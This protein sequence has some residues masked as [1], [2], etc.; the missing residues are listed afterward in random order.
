MDSLIL[1]PLNLGFFTQDGSRKRARVETTRSLKKVKVSTFGAAVEH[2]INIDVEDLCARNILTPVEPL[3]RPRFTKQSMLTGYKMSEV[4]GTGK[5]CTVRKAVDLCTRQTVAIKIMN[6]YCESSMEDMFTHAE[7]EAQLLSELDHPNIVKFIRQIE[8]PTKVYTVLEYVQGTDL[9]TYVTRNP[10]E[11]K[12]LFKQLASTLDY[13]HTQGVA[14]RDVKP[15][16]L[17]VDTQGNL[18]IV[19]FGM[20]VRYH[21]QKINTSCGTPSYAS[22]EA[23]MG[24]NYNGPELDSWSVGVVLFQMTT[25]TLPF[26]NVSETLQGQWNNQAPQLCKETRELVQGLLCMEPTLRMTLRQA[27][28]AAW[29]R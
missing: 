6:R 15:Q 10:K 28:A 5:T 21:G 18:K 12:K 19:D 4:L 2:E 13:C 17:L 29:C 7:R 25:S 20:S 8:T 22:P 3:E 27:A 26:A 9:Q 23:I 24:R 16:N 11:I 1:A 14:H